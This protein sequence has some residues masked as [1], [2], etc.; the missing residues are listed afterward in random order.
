MIVARALHFLSDRQAVF[1]ADQPASFVKRGNGLP[2]V[3]L[4]KAHRPAD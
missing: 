4:F 2:G 1:Q 3:R